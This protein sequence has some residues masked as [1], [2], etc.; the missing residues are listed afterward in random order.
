MFFELLKRLLK[1]RICVVHLVNCG[2]ED[3]KED[4]GATAGRHERG[5]I[6]EQAAAYTGMGKPGQSYGDM[7]GF[8]YGRHGGGIFG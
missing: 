8:G 6:G 4:F 7:I 5:E 2:I 3:V 1:L